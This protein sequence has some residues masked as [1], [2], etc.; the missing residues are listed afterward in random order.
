LSTILNNTIFVFIV[1]TIINI[2]FVNI[3]LFFKLNIAQKFVIFI[4]N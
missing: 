3:L 2:A 1:A 4:A